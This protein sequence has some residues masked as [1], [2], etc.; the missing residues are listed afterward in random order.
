MAGQSHNRRGFTLIET[1]AVLVILAVLAVCVT[2]GMHVSASV[3]VEADILR[4]HLGY[5]QSLAM[6][7]NVADWSV[8][9]TASSYM[10]RRDGATAPVTWPGENSATHVLG[11]GVTIG[12]GAGTLVFNEWGAPVATYVVALT[13][14]AQTRAVT[15]TG[16]TGM[17]P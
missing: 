3:A 4:S 5:A 15:V 9:F 11:G 12:G 8:V 14:G 7:N 13:D 6:A 2:A 17:I 16:F 10:L 1:V